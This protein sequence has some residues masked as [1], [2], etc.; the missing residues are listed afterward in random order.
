[1]PRDD[2]ILLDIVNEKQYIIAKIPTHPFWLRT[3]EKN[4][5]IQSLSMRLQKKLLLSQKKAKKSKTC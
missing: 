4:W 1:M 5:K 3:L 2:A